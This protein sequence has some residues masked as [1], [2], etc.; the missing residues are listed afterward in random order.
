MSEVIHPE[1]QKTG[2]LLKLTMYP[3]RWVMR[4]LHWAT[5]RTPNAKIEN[6]DNQ[7]FQVKRRRGKGE[8]R[9]R[10]YRPKNH[11]EPLP[12][13][14]YF[15][16]GGYCINSPEA[17][18]KEIQFFLD[19]CPCVVIAP[20]YTKSIHAPYPAAINDCE[21]TLDWL[22]ANQQN[23][24]I[25][26]DKLVV[27]GHSAGGGLTIALL[28]RIRARGDIAVAFHMPIYPMIDHRSTT[29]SAR[30]N[31]MPAWNTKL[32]K[33][34]WKMYLGDRFGKDN[35]PT[36]ASPAIE[37][38]FTGL[39]PAAT[40][41][42]SLDP[43][44]DETLNYVNALEDA[45]ITVQSKVFDRCYHAFDLVAP[46][47]SPSKEAI[48]FTQQCFRDAIDTYTAAQPR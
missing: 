10:V 17:A 22:L 42:G 33:L 30:D 47:A 23:L 40:F 18:H 14:L 8:I 48:A 36:D 43:F 4:L 6:V 7:T 26:S 21:D 13:L 34:A 27:G 31:D 35:I 24:N 32:N 44:L 29:P 12:V 5:N 41:V 20:D 38:D 19:A 45:G 37:N 46:E 39:P 25:R 3:K 28:L 2:R 9:V 15:H 16:G 11:S 1:L